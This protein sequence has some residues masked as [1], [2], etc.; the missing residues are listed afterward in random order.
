MERYSDLQCKVF[1]WLRFPL[2][3]GVVFI[4]CFGKPFD[5][6]AIDFVHL[7][8]MDCYNLFRVSISKVLTNVCVPTF[9]LISGYL[10]FI[11]LEK[12]CWGTYLKKLKKRSKSLLVP[13]LIWNTLCIILTVISVFRHEGW[14][15]VQDFF[16]DN[17]YAHLYWD[18]QVWN[19]DRTNLL[20]WENIATSPYCIPIWFLRDLMV[21]SVCSPLL[22]MLFKYT[23][24]L[25]V[26]LLTICYITAVFVPIPGFSIMAFLFFGVGGYCRMNGIDVTKVTFDYRKLIYMVAIILWIVCTMFNGHNTKQGDIVYPFYVI[27]GCMAIINLATYFVDKKKAVASE[28]LSKASFFIYLLHTILVIRVVTKVSVVIFGETNPL[29]MTMSYLFVPITTVAICLWVYS[30]LNKYTLALLKVLTGDR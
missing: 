22:F 21:V 8:G 4:H 28:F 13:F 15:G 27:F 23:R 17:N 3:V 2:I 16:V 11:G 18:C 19:L 5:Y 14:L 10:F 9:Y 12:W 26:M 7:M 20:G 24:I 25:G 6:D 29:L 30:I 1:D